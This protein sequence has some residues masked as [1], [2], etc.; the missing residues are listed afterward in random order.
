MSRILISVLLIWFSTANRALTEAPKVVVDIAP[1]HSL[2]SMVMKG[3][4][5]PTLI[6]PANASPHDYTLRPSAAKA[7]QNADIIFWMG[8]SLTPWLDRA[9]TTLM[10]DAQMIALLDTE[11]T[12]ILEVRDELTFDADHGDHQEHEDHDEHDEHKDHVS[13]HKDGHEH[14]GIDPHAWLSAKNASVWLSVIAAHLS[15]IDPKN[16]E[17][18]KTNAAV[19][20]KDITDLATD[21]SKT[22]SGVQGRSFIVYH[23]AFQYFENDFNFTAAGAI[24]PSDAAPVSPARIAA[25]RSM[26]E[27]EGIDCILSEPQYSQG[28]IQSV[29]SGTEVNLGIIDAIGAGITIGPDLYNTLMRNM[30]KTFADCF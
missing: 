10:K 30:A 14:H 6:I 24:S 3:V 7:L 23:D 2:V 29:S 20:Q 27:K 15:E 5:E 16:K 8:S 13:E 26:I 22:L 21:I 12:I 28:L 17:T 18:Y 19:G 9:T 11:D 25:I 4:G 1:V